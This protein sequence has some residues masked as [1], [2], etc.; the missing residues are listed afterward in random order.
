MP[1]DEY[2]STIQFKNLPQVSI[3]DKFVLN[4]TQFYETIKVWSCDKCFHLHKNV[5][6]VSGYC[7]SFGTDLIGEITNIVNGSHGYPLVQ[8]KVVMKIIGALRNDMLLVQ[9]YYREES[10]HY[11]EPR[12][13]MWENHYSKITPLGPHQLFKET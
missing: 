9:K 8:I 13:I 11:D 4:G 2:W 7:S 5:F 12:W 10:R 1:G 6:Q 3:G